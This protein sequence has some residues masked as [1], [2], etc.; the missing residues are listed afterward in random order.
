MTVIELGDITPGSD[1]PAPA[2]APP[3]FDARL[4]R[5]GALVLVAVFCL[6]AVTGSAR[7]EPRMFRTLWSVPFGSADRFTITSD[8][9][10]AT[11]MTNAGRLTAYDL[12][13]GRVRWSEPMPEPSGW[14]TAL[15]PA[16]VVLLPA[17]RVAQ[18]FNS[19]DGASYLTE[20]FKQTVALDAR[21]GRERWRRPG[22]LFSTTDTTAMLVERAGDSA[23]AQ[24]F[25]LIRLR[26]GA[27]L[28]TGPAGDASRMA[29][30]GPDPGRPDLLI[31][32]TARGDAKVIRMADGTTVAAARIDYQE[33]SQ[34]QEDFIDLFADGRNVYVRRANGKGES[35]TAYR[36]DTLARAWQVPGTARV[37][38]Y[39]CGPVVCAVQPDGVEAFDP[40]GGALRWRVP[41][42]Q[43][44]WPAAP[45]WI[46]V[47]AGRSGTYALVEAATGRRIT[48]LGPGT[49][50][51]SADGRAAFLLRG[52]PPVRIP[53]TR[54]SRVRIIPA[55]T[56]VSRIDLRT[57]AVQ[58][59]GLID[60]VSD[61]GCSATVDRLAC[62]TTTDRLVVAGI[63]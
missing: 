12:T 38:A 56:A 21:T 34:N 52:L 13:S 59:R 47:N 36:L 33:P 4:L 30:G 3:E 49:V 25:R 8:A 7:P 18:Q 54:T 48:D 35:L 44:A 14:P 61:Y 31:T 55:R 16:D 60:P 39:A 1:L 29:T 58:I 40:V 23:D 45:G 46:L 17:D 24:E 62:P 57:G 6:L 42:A 53:A 51:Q 10:F 41:T 43:D 37:N 9:L 50:A 26:D 20:Y 27:V 5:R 63:G 32:V 15:E 19:D 22:E 11:T 28:W 2:P